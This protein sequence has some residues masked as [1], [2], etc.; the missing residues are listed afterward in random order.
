METRQTERSHVELLA[1]FKS[2]DPLQLRDVSWLTAILRPH[3]KL[4]RMGW[5][6]SRLRI[7]QHPWEFAS[8]LLCL[9]EHQCKSYVEIG[10]STGGSF[11][12]TDAYLRAAVPGYARSVGYDRT[13]KLRGFDAYLEA[14][15]GAI[16]FRHASSRHMDISQERFDAGFVDARHVEAWVLQDFEKIKGSCGIVGFHDIVLVGGTVGAAWDRIKTSRKHLEFVATDIPESA[17][18]GIGAVLTK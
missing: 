2:A 9:A 18:C 4:N 12:A 17:R 14:V 10:T 11:M 3:C 1:T 6:G 5:R 7:I 13:S 16:E 8:W 15:A